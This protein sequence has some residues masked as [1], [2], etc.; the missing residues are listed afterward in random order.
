[1]SEYI[2][3]VGEHIFRGMISVCKSHKKGVNH[4]PKSLNVSEYF[5]PI[6]GNIQIAYN[7]MKRKDVLEKTIQL[8]ESH[9]A[10]NPGYVGKPLKASTHNGRTKLI[11]MYPCNN[12]SVTGSKDWIIVD[13]EIKRLCAHELGHIYFDIPFEEKDSEN[14]NTSDIRDQSKED[15]ANE[16][17]EGL[18]KRLDELHSK[19]NER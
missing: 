18:L 19:N 15:R 8:R 6:I 11:I 12:E 10:L 14:L 17:A 4:V 3:F 1:M 2:S 7:I 9:E 16:F 5:Q 13:R